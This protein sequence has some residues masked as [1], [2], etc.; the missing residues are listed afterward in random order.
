MITNR[1]GSGVGQMWFST[2]SDG[3]AQRL[4]P[5]IAYLAVLSSERLRPDP[6]PWAQIDCQISAQR[7]TG[8]GTGRRQIAARGQRQQ[9]AG[10]DRPQSTPT[11]AVGRPGDRLQGLLSGSASN[12]RSRPFAVLHDGRLRG[13]PVRQTR[14]PPYGLPALALSRRPVKTR[15]FPEYSSKEEPMQSEREGSR[16]RHPRRGGPVARAERLHRRQPHA[17]ARITL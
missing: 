8:T 15:R 12:L 7:G 9:V 5:R 17:P 13:D 6:L 2:V 4:A 3:A 10:T 16:Q 14:P 1:H 11:A